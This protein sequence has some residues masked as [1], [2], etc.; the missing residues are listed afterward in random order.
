MSTW[1]SLHEISLLWHLRCLRLEFST[2]WY[3][4]TARRLRHR[5]AVSLEDVV[6]FATI[7]GIVLRHLSVT[8]DEYLEFD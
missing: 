5:E 8:E 7:R 6:R 4:E 3:V 1:T 2:E